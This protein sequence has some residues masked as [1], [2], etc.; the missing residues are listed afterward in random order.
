[1]DYL[2]RLKYDSDLLEK[3]YA[4]ARQDLSLLA[5]NDT[6]NNDS[7]PNIRESKTALD[8]YPK[9]HFDVIILDSVRYTTI[10]YF[11]MSYKPNRC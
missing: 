7:L 5:D 4:L 1:M 3:A 8:F 9:N 10:Y 11:R 6:N 2:H